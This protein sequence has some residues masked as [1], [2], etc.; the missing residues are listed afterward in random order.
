MNRR[1]TRN[2][3]APCETVFRDRYGDYVGCDFCMKQ[4]DAWE[5]YTAQRAL[6]A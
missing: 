3:A 2:R 1:I 4:I 6:T 5:W